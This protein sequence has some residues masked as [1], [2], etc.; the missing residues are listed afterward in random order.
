MTTETPILATNSG[1]TAFKATF[2]ESLA[3]RIAQNP[4]L[5][6]GLSN[7]DL[8]K[9]EYD[10]KFWAR[11][12]QMEPEEFVSGL[13][14]IWMLLAGRGF[15]KSRTGAETT[16]DRVEHGRASRIALVAPSAADA[17]DVMIEGPSGIVTTSKPWFKAI[18]QPSKRRVTWPNGA[19]ATIYSAE[20]PDQ[21][22]GPQH[23]FA[24]CD[25]LAAWPH[26]TMQETWDNLMFGLR[27]GA[28]QCVITTTPRPIKII[29]D[30][31]KRSTTYVTRGST[32]ENLGNLSATFRE[33]IVET[34]A[35]T[36]LGRQEL[37]AEILDD[38]PGALWTWPMLDQ[39]RI[40]PGDT[41]P[42][43]RKAIAVDPA[44]SR[45]GHEVGICAGGIAYDG[46]GYLTGDYSLHGS[47]DEWG[48]RVIYAYDH[49]EADVI[50]VENNFGGEM[51]ANVVR[52][53]RPNAPIK[54]V[55]ASRGKSVR[56]EPVSMLNERGLI[57][58]AGSFSVLEDQLTTWLVEDGPN[59]RMD[60]YVWLWTELMPGRVKGHVWFPS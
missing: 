25:E 34:Y 52:N 23:D 60:A 56:A 55:R 29:R 48:Q 1:Q 14:L 32:Y 57:H 47:P 44:G 51:V 13:Y 16:N 31:I 41:P 4:S 10:W 50:V 40:K 33:Q 36:R 35:G 28:A 42:L 19:V 24:W 17:R 8:L 37:L 46:Q 20:D 54:E 2:Y 5:L 30:L 49:E 53:I 21:L 26:L 6:D 3:Q 58:H 7:E 22:R 9:L 27:M 43:K 15:G 11:P 59:D 39:Y 12:N 45:E 38:T 18:Y